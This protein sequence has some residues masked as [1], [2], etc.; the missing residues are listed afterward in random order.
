MD[1]QHRVKLEALFALLDLEC[2]GILGQKLLQRRMRGV[3]PWFDAMSPSGLACQNRT[4]R[5]DRKINPAE[6]D[7][8]WDKVWDV[9]TDADFAMCLQS[10]EASARTAAEY[11]AQL[12]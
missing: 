2:R 10:L 4:K 9:A 7:L 11:E 3:I 5:A 8:F 6:W 12:R 1:Q